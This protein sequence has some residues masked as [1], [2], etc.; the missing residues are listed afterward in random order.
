MA[1][2]TRSTRKP[3]ALLGR[4]IAVLRA[5]LDL[6]Q[7]DLARLSGV[8]RSSISQYECGKSAPDA[9]TL[10]RLLVAMRFQ[11][12]ALDLGSWFI[13]LL[14]LDCRLA[15][16]EEIEGA[17]PQ[18]LVTASALAT[19]LS[20]DLLAAN[21]TAAWLSR[22]VLHLE[23]EPGREGTPPQ[24]GDEGTPTRDYG[25]D[26]SRAKELWRRIRRLSPEGQAAAIRD[27][28]PGEQWAICELVYTESQL[29][30]GDDP[31]KATALCELALVAAGLAE[32][33]EGVRAKLRSLV[34]AHLGNA[35][36][37]RDDFA[38]AE[39]AFASAD[40]HWRIG[41]GT[42]AGL[43]EEGLLFALKAS[44]RRGQ[45]RFEEARELLD[46]ASLL[47]R[48]PKF[49]VQ[50]SVSQAKLLV[51]MGDL[52]EA[53]AILASV[54]E[55][56]ESK[57]PRVLLPVW[58]NLSDALS[59]LG[60]FEEAKA[61]LSE[62]RS[63]C[64][65]TGGELNR[66]RLLWTEARITAGLGDVEDGI[67]LMSRVRGEFASREMAY[68]VA[69]V[70][71]EIAS[72]HAGLGRTEPV[73]SLARHLTPIFQAHAVHREAL[74]AL[75]LFRQAAEREQVTEAFARDLLHYLRRA[76]YDPD[77]RFEAPPTP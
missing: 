27:A 73:K 33:G 67:A 13:D 41:E 52:E 40:E 61:L 42:A 74:A 77:L 54:K 68:D 45:G 36:R 18:P 70:S 21:Q 35:L 8:K 17:R 58:Q 43:I 29:Q 9:A 63:L 44:L 48:S 3:S 76:R 64:L 24:A 2:V 10:E 57:E 20:T 34:W 72:L 51:V 47:A 66:V 23:T 56:A 31:K 49:R 28:R 46:R 38:G 69:L 55:S 12:S 71:L 53:V 14:H 50:V 22:L 32:G 6:T 19:R 26:R 37:S 62:A 75:V 11:W 39:L 4:V 25:A 1:R 7:S 60:R 59:Q 15:E 5:S 16:G 30:C 65:K